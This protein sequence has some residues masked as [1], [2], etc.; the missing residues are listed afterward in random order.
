M[1][2]EVIILILAT[3]GMPCIGLGIWLDVKKRRKEEAS[4]RDDMMLCQDCYLKNQTVKKPIH[5]RADTGTIV[6]TEEHY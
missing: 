2:I 6:K 1:N 5:F 4:L 3:F